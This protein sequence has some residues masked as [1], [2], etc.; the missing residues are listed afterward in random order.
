MLERLISTLIFSRIA[1]FNMLVRDVNIRI[2]HFWDGSD[3]AF[4]SVHTHGL[5]VVG[6]QGW[7]WRCRLHMLAV[8]LTF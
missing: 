7:H 2:L 4:V 8:P 6:D 3:Q 1:T 5:R